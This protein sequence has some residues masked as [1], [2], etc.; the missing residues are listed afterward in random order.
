MELHG[1]HGKTKVEH[2]EKP[3]K[4]VSNNQYFS[5]RLK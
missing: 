2:R 1:D 4:S 5:S 3:G